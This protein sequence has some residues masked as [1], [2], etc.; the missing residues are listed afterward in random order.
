MDNSSV[1]LQPSNEEIDLSRIQALAWLAVVAV[2]TTIGVLCNAL[3]LKLARK[4]RMA[5]IWVLSLIGCLVIGPTKLVSTWICYWKI[6]T[7][8]DITELLGSCLVTYLEIASSLHLALE[9]V[10]AFNRRPQIRRRLQCSAIVVSHLTGFGGAYITFVTIADINKAASCSDPRKK[11][12]IC[13]RFIAIFCLLSGAL[14]ALLQSRKTS[15]F[16][17]RCRRQKDIANQECSD[18]DADRLNNVDKDSIVAISSSRP[19][20]PSNRRKSRTSSRM[21]ADEDQ[22]KTNFQGNKKSCRRHTVANI[23][24]PFS[25]S[26]RSK[27]E[28]SARDGYFHASGKKANEY[29]YVRKWS[30]DVTALADQLENPKSHAGSFPILTKGRSNELTSYQL[31]RMEPGKKLSREHVDAPSSFSKQ[32]TDVEIAAIPRFH[33][34][35]TASILEKTTEEAETNSSNGESLKQKMENASIIMLIFVS[36]FFKFIFACSI[37]SADVNCRFSIV[38]EAAITLEWTALPLALMMKNAAQFESLYRSILSLKFI[39]SCNVNRDDRCC[40]VN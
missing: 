31:R 17:T 39:C 9:A 3:T 14:A 27:L 33:D 25:H 38:L 16:E 22:Q 40:A 5:N 20:H 26:S 24:L 37:F 4:M 19:T 18:Q 6:G 15:T 28:M 13:H 34:S 35:C 32:T 11:S 8:E 2:A 29:R 30:V 21:S 1:K 7:Q 10:V 12:T 36:L 23:G